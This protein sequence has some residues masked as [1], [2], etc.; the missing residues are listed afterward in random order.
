MSTANPSAEAEQEQ[1][2]N[3]EPTRGNRFIF[4]NA[5]PSWLVSAILH[6]LLIVLL[7]FW[8][9][10]GSN[11]TLV[12]LL[13]ETEEQVEVEELE[14][15]D[16]TPTDLQQFEDAEPTEDEFVVIDDQA[17]EEEVEIETFELDQ[18]QTELD[19]PYE[20]TAVE[21]T[22]AIGI[23]ANSKTLDRSSESKKKMLKDAG[24]NE[25]SERAVLDALNWIVQ[26]QLPDGGWSFDHTTGPGAFRKTAGPGEARQARFGATAMAILPLLGAGQ[27]HLE[28]EAKF[29]EAIRRG[30]KYLVENQ[31]RV[32]L[33]G[34]EV[35][36]SFFEPEGNMYSHG[37]ATI[38]ICEAYAMTKDRDLLYPAQAAIN[39]I[40]YAQDET[41]GGWRYASASWR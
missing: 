25:A 5:V 27:T 37:L 3:E 10:P 7:A 21:P 39:F 23:T 32:A 19:D 1:Q 24:G 29:K 20:L 38:A 41:T 17:F 22:A 36:G 2:S 40:V 26:H 18:S 4:F 9:L 6:L 15:K 12:E 35:G 16:F 11:K 31:K 28:G 34:G 14:L 8:P 30:L 13:T 33:P